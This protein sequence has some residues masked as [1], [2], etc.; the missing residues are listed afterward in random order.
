MAAPRLALVGM[1]RAACA[2]VLAVGLPATSAEPEKLPVAG[3]YEGLML[4]VA[5][6]GRVTGSF[7][8]AQGEGVVKQ[9][10]FLLVAS[11]AM[12]PMSVV[13]W[14]TQAFSGTL[15]AHADELALKVSR[16]REHPGCASVLPPDEGQG[17]VLDR[18][19]EAQWIELR[20]VQAER[21]PMQADVDKSSRARGYLV[22]GDIV[23]VLAVRGQRM[24]V[25]YPG[26][27][28]TVRAWLDASDTEG[29]V[30]PSR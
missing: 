5:P 13:T 29:F 11:S 12:Q 30:P 17:L 7:Q 25:D 18:Q 4:A 9:C 6:D 14:S 10:R 1:A 16:L 3:M 21:A 26:A 24:L 28:R 2:W 19:S 23:A 22:R 8:Q 20:R 15:V 27:K